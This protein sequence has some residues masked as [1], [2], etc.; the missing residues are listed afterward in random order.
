MLLRNAGLVLLAWRLHAD[1]LLRFDLFLLMVQN[2]IS[3][4]WL[5]SEFLILLRVQLEH[6][7]AVGFLVKH[8][9]L[10]V[11]CLLGWNAWQALRVVASHSCFLIFN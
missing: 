10:V 8:D 11:V 3:L 9:L 5:R 7:L 2:L 1:D 6:F 4:N